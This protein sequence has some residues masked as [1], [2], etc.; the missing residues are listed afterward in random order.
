MRDTGHEAATAQSQGR[1]MQSWLRI[2]LLAACGAIGIAV[3]LA[4]ALHPSADAE[5][6]AQ[7]TR[8]PKVTAV[9]VAEP[10]LPPPIAAPPPAPVVAPYRD[11]IARQVG[12]LEETMQELE[13]SSH[14]R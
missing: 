9:V 14:R 10:Q 3:A 11:P 13:E 8:A 2:T 1:R 12:Q 7:N 5:H 6:T 4:I